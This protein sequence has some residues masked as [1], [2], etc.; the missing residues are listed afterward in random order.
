MHRQQGF[1]MLELAAAVLIATLLVVWSASAL[2]HKINDAAA[3]SSAV[4]MLSIKKAAQAYIER[5]AVVLASASDTAALSGKGYADW[6]LPSLAE[7]KTDKLLSS[8]FPESGIRAAGVTVAIMRS[9]TC[10]D[11]DCRLEALIYSNEAI[12]H[13]S[14]DRV[15][16]QM[17][18]QW[19][20]ASQ[21]WG[22]TVKPSSPHQISGAAFTFSNPPAP[23]MELLPVGTVAMAV[24]SEQLGSLEFLRVGD[25]RDPQFQGQATVKGDINAQA[26]LSIQQ[27]LYLEAQEYFHTPCSVEGAAAREH[28]GGLLVCRNGRWRAAGRRNAGGFVINSERD[29]KD[30]Y[31]KSTANPITGDCSCPVG[32]KALLVSDS[33]PDPAPAPGSYGQT[34][35][36]ICIE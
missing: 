1:A 32:S 7:L 6:A 20:M 13:G 2:V 15:N 17:I 30:I 26:S 23:A 34:W 16:E 25:K 31:G 18:A 36:Y 5:Y 24:T 11:V 29:C 10:P 22:G 9:G 35:G 21:G 28:E 8:G 19:L 12:T 3:Q 4:W 27:Y 14:G 33:G